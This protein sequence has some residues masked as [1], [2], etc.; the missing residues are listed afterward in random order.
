MADVVRKIEITAALSNDYQ[1]AFK[2]AADVAK[3]TSKQLQDLTKREQEL[4]KLAALD[5]QRA[6]AA[7]EGN[8]KAAAKSAADYDKLAAKL[9]MVGKS[10]ADIDAELKSIGEQKSGI[11]ALNKA[12][13]KQAELGKTAQN[14]Q[15]LSLAYQKTK[16]P[17]LLKALEQQ[18]KK[19]Q[20]M[21]GVVPKTTRAVSG[22]GDALARIPGPIGSTV[23]SL[24]GLSQVLKGPAGVVALL[25]GA[26]VA[27]VAATKKLFDLGVT[28]AKSGDKIIKTADALGI[29][30][31]AYQELS[32]AMQRG[33]ASE[34]DFA[35]G[36]KHIQEQMGA[37][38][39]GQSR[40]KKA[41][42][43]FGITMDE[44][45]SMNAEE[46]FYRISDGIA[47]IPDPAKRMKASVQLLGGAGDKLAH[48]MS[49]GAA[50]LDALRKAAKDT[51]NVRTRKELE[52]AAKASDTMLDAQM[53]LKGA[54]NDIAFAV[55][56]ELT[57]AFKD[58][59][60]WIR[61]N[62]ATIQEFAQFAVKALRGIGAVVGTVFKGITAGIKIVVEG[63]KFWQDKFAA[64]IETV[65]DIGKR[66][67]QVFTEDIPN[68][69]KAAK[70]W[71]VGIFKAAFDWLNGVIDG[72]VD[73]FRTVKEWVTGE[74]HYEPEINGV[75]IS[76]MPDRIDRSVKVQI[77]VDAR[78]ADSA[79]GIRSQRAIEAATP[80]TA[81]AIGAELNRYGEYS[82][83]YE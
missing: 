58:F 4:Q 48:A 43:Q 18:R 79:A 5:A 14:I 70:D 82:G 74:E 25:G 40:A 54:M 64:L 60:G 65:V 71:I 39:Q 32:Y 35:T 66:I 81:R 77:N 24:Q 11:E 47:G 28:A 29:S 7:Q 16:D 61:E 52:Q 8:A 20:A 13:S 37:A 49:G 33:G 83:A 9:G 44:I 56:P 59:G 68:A 75:P 42:A 78:G 51:G 38:V 17:A 6:A 1:A 34:E 19:F 15:K 22:F 53:S 3:D 50:G 73:R 80:V 63:I 69:L 72:I 23:R 62:R 46:M 45:K 31:D 41:F 27:A 10:V 21:G 57:G 26:A 12:A 67:G 36:I 55:L 30:T 76:Q 2:A